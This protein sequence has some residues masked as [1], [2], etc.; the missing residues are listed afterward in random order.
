MVSDSALGMANR[1]FT[2]NRRPTMEKR[3]GQSI[4]KDILYKM[5]AFLCAELT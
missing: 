5:A 1:L 2:G 3:F 4:E